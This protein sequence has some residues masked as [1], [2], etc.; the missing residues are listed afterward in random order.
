MDRTPIVYGVDLAKNVF[1]M[2]W[3]DPETG[4]MMNRQVKR[5]G[6]LAHFANRA[7]CLV[8]M[9]VIRLDLQETFRGQVWSVYNG[10]P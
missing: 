10:V 3:V 6:V 2:Q 4:E 8:G 7:P 1:Q 5:A 9:E